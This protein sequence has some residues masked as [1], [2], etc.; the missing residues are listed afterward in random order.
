[1]AGESAKGKGERTGR[2]K[3]SLQEKCNLNIC[4]TFFHDNILNAELW[5]SQKLAEIVMKRI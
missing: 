3:L 5:Q 4:S 1:M 2:A